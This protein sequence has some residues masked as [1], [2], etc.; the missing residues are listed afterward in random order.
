MLS[1]EDSLWEV[2]GPVTG[3][4]REMMGSERWV[5]SSG[6][7]SRQ[8]GQNHKQR[9]RLET[10]MPTREARRCALDIRGRVSAL[11]ISLRGLQDLAKV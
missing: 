9:S 10:L 11:W 7:I 4:V 2:G 6:R 8:K 3:P 5:E 1:R